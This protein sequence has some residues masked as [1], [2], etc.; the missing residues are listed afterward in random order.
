MGSERAVHSLAVCFPHQT[1]G[2]GCGAP[3][4]LLHINKEAE[5]LY[6]L[7]KKDPSIA[8]PKMPTEWKATTVATEAK[9]SA[10]LTSAVSNEIMQTA[11][12]I[13][14]GFG[15][16][17]LQDEKA[18]VTEYP[19]SLIIVYSILDHIKPG[20]AEI[21][22]KISQT[23]VAPHHL[24]KKPGTPWQRSYCGKEHNDKQGPA[25]SKNCPLQNI[26]IPAWGLSGRSPGITECSTHLY[27]TWR[28]M[29]NLMVL[30]K[31][32]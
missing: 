25:T 9:L 22:K 30:Q 17:H 1:R 20:T 8:I 29:L 28:Q 3:N 7:F 26:W 16:I 2:C 27:L 31:P 13:S 24:T 11:V 23:T 12:A 18:N 15:G 10:A 4:I 5:A 32:L 6:A 14:Q 21:R 19:M